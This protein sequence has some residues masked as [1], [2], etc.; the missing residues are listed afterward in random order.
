VTPYP[1]AAT[2][3]FPTLDANRLAPVIGPERITELY[4]MAAAIRER[5]GG[6]RVINVNSTATGGG[7]A[8]LLYT[9]LGYARGVGVDADWVVIRGDSEFFAVTKRLHNWLHGSSGDGGEIGEAE[10]ASYERIVEAN[11][12]GVLSA[13][14]PGDV[15]IVH[16]PQP[17]G[18]VPRLVERGARV[19]WRCHVGIDRP[20]EWT[21]RAWA[22]LR[23]YVEPAH[24]YVFSRGAFAPSF[25]APD[26][27][28]IIA[29]SIDPLSAKNVELSRAQVASLL[30]SSDLVAWQRPALTDR[31]ARPADVVREGS[32]PSPRVPLVV[33][34]SRWDRL[35]DMGGVLD[36]F[37][38]HVSAGT[39]AHLVLAG[40][41][42]SG[43]ADDPEAEAIWHEM[44][45]R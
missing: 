16:D 1:S 32:A 17:A 26:R 23:P 6:Q 29:P 44:V 13:V 8:E 39:G 12:E 34:I 43:V 30:T 5:L 31:I 10:R 36:G 38:G 24:A 35:K 21:E 20:N 25:L 11:A 2:V 42:F 28:A 41:A 27:L 40:P 14:H 22:F 4:D 19:V 45:E 33:Q 7:V 18:L 37:V 9:L 15:V 3:Q